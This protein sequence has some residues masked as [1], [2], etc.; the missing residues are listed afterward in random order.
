MVFSGPDFH[1]IP[2][3][4]WKVLR[5]TVLQTPG[6][7]PG[8][9][10]GSDVAA[11]KSREDART[12]KEILRRTQFLTCPLFCHKSHEMAANADHRCG[13]WMRHVGT[14]L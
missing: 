13:I 11:S 12:S 2:D 6:T 1:D 7:N 10:L 5:C 9:R 14:M 4:R 8:T 3:V